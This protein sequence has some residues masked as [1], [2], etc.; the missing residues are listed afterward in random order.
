MKLNSLIFPAPESTYSPTSLETTV[1]VP[2]NPNHLLAPSNFVLCSYNAYISTSRKY[3]DKLLIYFHG[4]AEDLGSA[5]EF[6]CSLRDNLKIN[7][8]AMEYQGYGWYQGTPS[9]KTINKDA[10][11]VYDFFVKE[12]GFEEKNIMLFGRSIGSGVATNLA[13]KRN[14]GA[15]I[16]MSAFSSFKDVTRNLV[17]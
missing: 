11:L 9:E 14:M 16:L 3:S 4:N 17:G 5:S 15:L 12:I 10:E 6:L 2:K 13:S 7:I 1:L 8:L